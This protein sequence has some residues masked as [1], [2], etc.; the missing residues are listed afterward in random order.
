MKRAWKKA[1][2]LAFLLVPAVAQAQS[3]IANLPAARNLLAFAAPGLRV[4][5]AASSICAGSAPHCI[6]VNW[7]PSTDGAANPTLAYNMYVWLTSGTAPVCTASGTCTGVTP[8]NAAPVV[9]GCTSNTTC[10][11]SDTA[12]GPGKWSVA[13]TAILN[14]SESAL[15][16]VLAVEIKP[17]AP[18]VAG[19]GQ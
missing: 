11:Y 19:A 12:I 9:A 4:E 2:V 7:T 3:S 6:N 13:V 17:A 15:S 1:M 14:G 10:I 18:V 16:N 5:A 8:V